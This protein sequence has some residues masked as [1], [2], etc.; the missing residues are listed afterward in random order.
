M[1]VLPFPCCNEMSLMLY[2]VDQGVE[3]R[4]VDDGNYRPY[5]YVTYGASGDLRRWFMT[6]T[7]S[8]AFLEFYDISASNVFSFMYYKCNTSTNF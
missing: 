7:H 4:Y 8:L 3:K 5:A 2:T 1:Y 6:Q